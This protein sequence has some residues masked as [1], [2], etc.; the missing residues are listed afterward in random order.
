[1]IPRIEVGQRP[2]RGS[3]YLAR[4]SWP[5]QDVPTT[6]FPNDAQPCP[7]LIPPSRP[8]DGDSCPPPLFCP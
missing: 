8:L 7:M 1:M 2:K 3:E 6:T 4:F 5:A